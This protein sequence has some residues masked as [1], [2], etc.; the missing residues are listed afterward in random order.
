MNF[1]ICILSILV[2]LGLVR[3]A[4]VEDFE[5][6]ENSDT[7][8]H[9]NVGETTLPVWVRGN[10]SSRKFVIYINGGPGLT[11][12]DIA[13]ADMFDWSTG[14][15]ENFAI[16][17]YDQRGCGNS[18]GNIDE[19][20]L[21]IQQYVDDLDAIVSVLESA[22]ENPQIYLM[23][24]SFGGFIGINYLL[25]SEY[26][27]KIAGWI[28]IDGA[29]NFDFDLSWQYRRTFLINLANEEILKG[30]MIE[31]WTNALEWTDN[32]PTITTREQKNTWQSYV[33]DPGEIIIPEE[34]ATL[35]VRQYLEIGFLSSYN[36]FP[37]YLS[38]NLEIVNDKLNAD[39]EGTN[40]IAE[41][42]N[43]TIPSLL[44]W[45]RY[46][47]LIVPEEGADVFN[48]FGTLDNDKYFI[49]LSNSSH[50]PYISDP[51][52]FKSE[53]IDFVLKY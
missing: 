17:Y 37:A 18:Q 26:E 6:S 33:G 40:L 22:Y 27:R 53:I 34:L 10:T 2:G 39:A 38:S 7:F 51:L 31:H 3:C 49:V 11:S 35:S 52:N 41:V 21:T 45:G 23:G 8:F 46:D 1:R 24:H 36:P 13:R 48:N 12:I 9:V 30:N 19:S 14:L 5:I 43:V 44:I 29:Y 50:E 20:T 28:S 32:N 16:V 4:K 47:D 42:S 25:N 15:E